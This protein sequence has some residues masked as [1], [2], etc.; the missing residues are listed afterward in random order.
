M[1]NDNNHVIDTDS[2][3]FQQ[4]DSELRGKLSSKLHD[5]IDD[6]RR[7]VATS[8]SNRDNGDNIPDDK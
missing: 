1:N 4:F 3:S 8:M 7:E 2:E 5:K 6:L